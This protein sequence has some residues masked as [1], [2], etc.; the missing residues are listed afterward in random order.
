[1]TDTNANIDGG[2]EGVLVSGQAP[3]T[4]DNYATIASSSAAF[5][6]GVL[7]RNAYAAVVN[8]SAADGQAAITGYYYGVYV[9]GPFASISNFGRIDSSARY[10][11]AGVEMFGGQIVNGSAADTSASIGGERGVLGFGSPSTL[12]NFGTIGGS[13][14]GVALNAGGAI[15]NGSGSDSAA[16]IAGGGRGDAVYIL[17]ST[18]ATVVN[19]GS[20]ENTA[21]GNGIGIV[22]GGTVV[23]G[24]T[25]DTVATII[26]NRTGVYMEGVVALSISNYG[27]ITGQTANGVF[28]YGSIGLV[29]GAA[30]DTGAMIGGYINGIYS[31]GSATITNSGTISG[32][33][34]TVSSGVY[35]F[36]GGYVTNGA[37]ASTAA[38]IGAAG[39]GVICVGGS[40]TITNF[41]TISGS[42]AVGFESYRSGTGIDY[43]GTGT[44]VNGGTIESTQGGSGIAV[45]FGT[46]SER[47]V[48]ESG[49]VFVGT[50][51]GGTG[52][53]TLELAAG[54]R[55]NSLS[56][57]G[58]SFTNFGSI[59]VDAGASWKL[60]GSNALADGSSLAIGPAA[61]LNIT[62]TLD[63]AGSGTLGGGGTLA[64]SRGA[65]IEIGSAGGALPSTLTVDP[66]DTLT[67][68]GS[69]FGAV[70]VNGVL[71][72]SGTLSLNRLAGTGT[73]L[74]DANSVLTAQSQAS[75][76]G[77]TFAGS[78]AT[79]ALASTVSLAGRI[80]GFGAVVHGNTID[81]L[82][83]VSTSA[84][85]A[86]GTLSVTGRS[87]S[88]TQLHFAGSYSTASFVL[89]S[90][91]HGGT[92]IGFAVTTRA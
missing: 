48:I 73:A 27:T 71:I 42:L 15:T 62:G 5:G 18:A 23:N 68:T 85:F 65:V 90:D 87:G 16:L 32:G 49:A 36:G 39:T 25:A 59:T 82:N 84:S 43:F 47:L 12:T 26:G 35:L 77:F 52:I 29:N 51:V 24:T 86:H 46:G 11:G 63:L 55:A 30:S 92:D 41:G 83:L 53:N 79:L 88:V 38:T 3:V 19:Y 22:P 72:A 61:V 7:I 9:H 60:S 78:G 10:G 45:L 37:P 64:I 75:I 4:L 76:R 40:G 74:I 80:T 6:I 44:V 28:V 34:S 54:G 57:L 91:H 50:V 69:I 14:N 21:A 81:L 58:T 20:I 13:G 66:G 8:G 67:A 56:G 17:A 70:S 1:M 31:G 89:G 33:A 2:F